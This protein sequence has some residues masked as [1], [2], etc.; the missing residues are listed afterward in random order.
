MSIAIE[1]IDCGEK[2]AKEIND[3]IRDLEEGQVISIRF[4][5]PDEEEEKERD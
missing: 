5:V 1:R 4:D 2:T 3:I